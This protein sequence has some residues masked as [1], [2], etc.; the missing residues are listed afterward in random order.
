M[1]STHARLQG[2]AGRARCAWRLPRGGPVLLSGAVVGRG[3]GVAPTRPGSR[4]GG[5]L[6]TQTG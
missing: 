5:S 1:R 6:G 4:P 2:E 3:M